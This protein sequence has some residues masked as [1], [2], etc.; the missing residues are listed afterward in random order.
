M[1]R[2]TLTLAAAGA[3]LLGAAPAKAVTL[4][5]T[6]QNPIAS[7]TYS[8][9]LNRTGANTYSVVVR[10]NNDG[11]HAADASGP[12]KH[13]VGRISVAF[14]R[15]D[16]SIIDATSGSGGTNNSP[17]MP[18]TW[19]GSPWTTVVLSDAIRFNSPAIVNDVGPFGENEFQGNITLASSEDPMLFTV[20]LQDGTQQWY[21][22]GAFPDSGL[23]PEPASLALALP[24]L[25]P[26]GLMLLRRRSR[27][28]PDTED[29]L[30]AL[31]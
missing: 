30:D 25:L 4:N 5:A 29:E 22:Q 6:A 12:I 28:S 14:F 16:F 21:T 19:V 20:A 17:D 7:G 24:G 23:V 31:A 13:S 8:V 11:R 3:L 2:L 15:S 10:G 26:V 18:P 9:S 27:T 1:N